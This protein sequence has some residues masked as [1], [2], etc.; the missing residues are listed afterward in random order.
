MSFLSPSSAAN[1]LG[2]L[3]GTSGSN[4]SS[5][6][7]KIGLGANQIAAAGGA[8]PGYGGQAQQ[9]INY[10]QNLNPASLAKMGSQPDVGQTPITYSN[11]TL[12]RLAANLPGY[13]R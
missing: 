13:A 9:P 12:E 10:F 4:V 8:T 7:D 1:G 6:A 2:S 11:P 3:L 5:W